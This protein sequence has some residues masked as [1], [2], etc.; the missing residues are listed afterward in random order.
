[1]NAFL[2]HAWRPV[3]LVLLAVTLTACQGNLNVK[4]DS[5]NWGATPDGTPIKLFTLENDN[6]L[7]CKITNYGAIVTEMHTPDR[8]GN[9]ADIVLGF[10][11][12]EGYTAGHPYFGAIV[13]RCA[14]RIA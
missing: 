8:D 5:E 3:A 1:M 6:G 2:T 12:I 7:V 14:N 11:N 10:N 4:I 13:G 9:M